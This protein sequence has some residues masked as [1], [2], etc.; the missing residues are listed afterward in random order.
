[1]K[2]KKEELQGRVAECTVFSQYST[3]FRSLNSTYYYLHCC[4]HIFELRWN[5]NKIEE[6][7]SRPAT[8]PKNVNTLESSVL[9]Q[10]GLT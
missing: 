4:F 8:L 9:L 5:V 7:D 6:I 3:S 10:H 1:M 2:V